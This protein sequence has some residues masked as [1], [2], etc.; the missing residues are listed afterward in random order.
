MLC[1]SYRAPLCPKSEKCGQ[2][3]E[4]ILFRYGFLHISS[5]SIHVHTVL[6][7][8][9][10]LAVDM[11]HLALWDSRFMFKIFARILFTYV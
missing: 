10:V 6:Q 11:C 2:W 7:T 1:G 5:I 4:K 9:S 8:L 3:N